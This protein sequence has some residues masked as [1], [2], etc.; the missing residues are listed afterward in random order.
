MRKDNSALS[1]FEKNIK[2][3]MN[4]KILE[5]FNIMNSDKTLYL[6]EEKPLVIAT[7]I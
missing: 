6:V 7:N 2:K 4:K 1:I 5:N 3:M